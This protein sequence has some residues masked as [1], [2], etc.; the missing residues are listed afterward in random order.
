M[1]TI[2][3]VNQKGGVGKTT[4][5]QNIGAALAAMGY[6]VLLVDLDPQGSLTRCCGKLSLSD[7][8]T[9]FEA[10]T[11]QEPLNQVILSG[12][13]DGYDFIPLDQRM[14][15]KESLFKGKVNTLKNT[16][17]QA[18]SRYDYVLIDCCPGLNVFTLMG[19]AAADSAIIPVA[20]QYLALDGLVQLMETI[21]LVKEKVNPDLKIG[22]VIVTMFDG[23]RNI[24]KNIADAVRK[25]FPQTFKANV[26][27]NSKTAEAPSAG[28]SVI[29]YD[30]KGAG[31]AAY[32]DI[33]KE[34]IERNL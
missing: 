25:R 22:G 20:A 11:G 13:P 26:R 21:T 31:A 33:A 23:R 19:L 17:S 14:S 34:I 16:L 6:K 32:M 4:S 29:K 5:C 15:G 2:A 3:F 8:G 9:T 1:R 30:P 27:Y 7:Q 10:M 28:M 12:D 24:D 18:K